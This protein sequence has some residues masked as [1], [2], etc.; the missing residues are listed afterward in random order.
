MVKPYFDYF[1]LPGNERYYDFTWGPV[2]L[3]ALD[4]IDS[5]PD[6]VGVV[7][8]TSSL[9][10]SGAGSVYISLEYRVHALPAVFF[11]DAWLDGLGEVAVCGVGGGCGAGGA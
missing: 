1:T 3:F 6:G 2:H 4:D 8:D 9:A 5:E 7:V 10:E 11:G